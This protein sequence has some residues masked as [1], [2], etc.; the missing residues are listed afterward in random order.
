MNRMPVL[1]CFFIL[2]LML[3]GEA[4]GHEPAG[5]DRVT[6][7]PSGAVAGEYGTWVVTYHVGEEGIR[8]GGGIRVQLPDSWHSGIR[9][10]AKRLQ[11]SDPS[12][13]HYVSGRSSVA[14]VR[15]RTTVESEPE[16]EV[17]LVKDGRAGLDGR[18]ERYVFVVRVEVLEGE[19]KN[20][21]HLSVVYGDTSGGSRGMEAAVISTKPEPV[22]VAVDH[23]GHGHFELLEDRPTLESHGGQATELLLTGPSTLVVGEPARLHLA[24]VDALANPARSF[25]EGVQLQ[26]WQGEA[27]VPARVEFRPDRAWQTV[28]LVPVGPGLVRIEARGLRSGLRAV[29]NPM[30]VFAQAPQRRIFWG[31][32]H[33]HSQYSWDGVGDQ[34]FEYARDIAGLDFYAMTD[35]SRTPEDGLTRGLHEHVWEE[36]VLRNE[37][38]YEPGRFVTLHAYEASF[39]TPFGHHNVYFRGGPG[40]LL[41]PGQVTL[42]ELW[43]ALTA[44]QALTVPHHT[45]KMPRVEWEPHDPEFRRNFEIYSGH[46]L[47]E[48]YDP[49]HPLAFEQS[50]FTGPGRS[51]TEPQFAQDAWRRGLVLSTIAASDDHRAQPGQPHWG[52]AAVAAT[53]LTREGV[54]DALYERRTYGSTGARILLD[55]TVNGTPMGREVRSSGPP[56]LRIEVHGTA[57]LEWV[58]ILRYSRSDEVFRVIRRFAPG[59]LD[60]E[61]RGIDKGF[62]EDSIYYVRVRQAGWI[63]DRVAMAW[64]TPIWVEKGTGSP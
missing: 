30:K 24:V 3:V 52:L 63:R 11:A 17:L 45:G 18:W 16:P 51:R 57:S 60:F 54:F 56:E 9:N 58:E 44:G 10:S 12:A 32:L 13:H 43:N 2:G 61:W 62:R 19:L 40:P 34:N 59:R 46:G 5:G 41:A 37:E 55:F 25:E 21:D 20:G 48:S 23:E 4:G 47:S 14:A 29:S 38:H 50:L 15:L 26:V 42:P 35:H 33:S 31:D 53:G 7:S 36:Y 22:L 1:S 8:T 64:S 49:S 28:E 6:V 27:R 39:G